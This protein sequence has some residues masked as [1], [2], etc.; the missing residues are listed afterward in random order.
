MKNLVLLAT[1]IFSVCFYACNDDDD[2][3]GSASIQLS[4]EDDSKS[5]IDLEGIEV[6][7][8]N[9]IDNT[10]SVAK[11]NTDGVA[12]FE[13][14]AAGTY[15][16]LV[17]INEPEKNLIINGTRNDIV[18]V[19]EETA[20]VD[21]ELSVVNP[22][23]GLVIKEIY[24]VGANDGY[25]SLFKDQFIEIF[26][27]SGETLHA[28]GMYVANLYGNTGTAGSTTDEP[29]TNVLSVDDYVYADFIDRIPGG[30]ADYPVE[31]GKSIIIALNAMN[32]KEDNPAAEFAVDNTGADL[33][34]YSVKWL[35]DKGLMGNSW[36]DF[37]NPEVPNM[38]N[39]YMMAPQNL[40]LFN[41]YGTAAVLVEKDVEFNDSGIVDYETDKSSSVY[42]LMRIPVEKVIDGVEILENSKSGAFK[43]LPKKIDAGFSY[44]KADGGAFYSSMSSRR[45]IDEES[46]KALKRVVLLDSNN[47]A[48][49]FESIDVPSPRSYDDVKY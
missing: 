7:L 36:F 14:L 48:V 9:V 39:V 28:D 29:I 22:K 40:W 3:L 41:S 18:I 37:D 43:R 11:T 17:S 27:N 25:K 13:V 8:T 34:R 19:S 26:N 33:E 44:L 49:D 10:E 42:K 5:D 46:S 2:L 30:G 24:S 4:V 35:E 15:N 6:K 31:P 1:F 12:F 23:A 32:F 20:T 21:V 45:K 16:A 47:S 38:T